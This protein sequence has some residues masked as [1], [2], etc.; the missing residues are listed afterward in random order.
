MMRKIWRLWAL[1][2][3]EKP[4]KNNREADAIA[5]VRSIIVLINLFTAIFITANIL[6]GWGWL[7]LP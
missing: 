3:G 5:A 2:L 6:V 1:A 7:T 4:S